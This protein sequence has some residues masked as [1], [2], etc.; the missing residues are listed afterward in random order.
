MIGQD[1]E[2]SWIAGITFSKWG[3]GVKI[4]QKLRF[5]KCNCEFLKSI[6]SNRY[7]TPATKD[8]K[9]IIEFYII[10]LWFYYEVKVRNEMPL[11]LGE[12]QYFYKKSAFFVIWQVKFLKFIVFISLILNVMLHYSTY[13]YHVMSFL[14]L[15]YILGN[16]CIAIA[17][18]SERCHIK[19]R[20]YI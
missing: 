8:W 13:M 5:W 4:W 1:V 17:F 3:C 11:F 16:A 9:M 12:N 7:T 6:W 2:V 14:I 20:M 19:K 10:L 15:R 18:I